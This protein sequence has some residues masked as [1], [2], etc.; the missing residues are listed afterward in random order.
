MLGAVLQSVRN[1]PLRLSCFAVMAKDKE[2]GM[3][4]EHDGVTGL[5]LC[6]VCRPRRSSRPHTLGSLLPALASGAIKRKTPS[7]LNDDVIQTA[8]P[9]PQN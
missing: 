1:V 9:C 6:L 7:G 3:M 5:L 2:G 4:A 8:G